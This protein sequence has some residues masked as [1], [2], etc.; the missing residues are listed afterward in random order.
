[1]RLVRVNQCT[2]DSEAEVP[3]TRHLLDATGVCEMMEEH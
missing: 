3:Q 1:M 2:C